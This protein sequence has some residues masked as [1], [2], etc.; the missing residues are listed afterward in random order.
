M[1]VSTRLCVG[2]TSSWG[3]TSR[4]LSPLVHRLKGMGH[5]EALLSICIGLK[6]ASEQLISRPQ[7]LEPL[8]LAGPSGV[9]EGLKSDGHCLDQAQ[10]GTKNPT[11]RVGPEVTHVLPS[12]SS[13]LYLCVCARV[14][15]LDQED[16]RELSFNKKSRGG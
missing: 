6:R 16:K 2:I 7:A 14:R 11:V 15:T 12:F 5:G 4:L 1:V 13:P 8:Y 9:P 10:I 3:R